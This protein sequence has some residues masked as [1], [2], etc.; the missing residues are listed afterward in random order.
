MS[1][2]LRPVVDFEIHTVPTAMLDTG[3]SQIQYTFICIMT[4]YIDTNTYIHIHEQKKEH[5]C[6]KLIS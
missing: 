2:N 6:L 3:K 4:I 1:L 5:R